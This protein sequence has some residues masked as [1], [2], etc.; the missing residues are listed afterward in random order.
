MYFSLKEMIK[1]GIHYGHKTRYWNPNMK[2]YIYTKYNNIHII[3]LE[4]TI[5]LFKK[6]LKELKN[7]NN[8]KKKILFVGT[9]KAAS[10]EIKIVAKKCNQYFINNRWLG[11]TLT[12]W[13]TVKKSIK[14]FKI[15]EEQYKNGLFN[16]LVKKENLFKQK[17]LKKLNNNLEGIKNMGRI[18]DALF[19]IDAKYE[20]IAIKEAKQLNIKIFA[21]V[22]TNTNPT[23]IDYIIPGNDDSKKSIKWF[24]NVISHNLNLT[25]KEKSNTQ[26]ICQ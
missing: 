16:K 9:K 15:L 14:Y 19:V 2:P 5:T 1:A 21:I 11:G 18:P 24:L 3:N 12:N 23:N 22:D 25:T 8:S 6:A 7:I 13:K 17:I 4:Q 26:E 20:N 10:K